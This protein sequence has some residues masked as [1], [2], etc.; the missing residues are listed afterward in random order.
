M[1]N[2]MISKQLD[3][4]LVPVDPQKVE[5]IKNSTFVGEFCLRDKYGNWV[6]SPAQIYWQEKPPVEGYSNYF[7]LFVRDGD[8]LI[9]SGQSAVDEEISAIGYGDEIIFSRYRH[10]YRSSADGAVAIDGGRDY[11]KIVGTPDE[12]LT[13]KIEGPHL[14]IKQRMP[15]SAV[16]RSL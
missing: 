2:V 16:Q 13:L 8:V 4:L 5:K 12:F 7:A 9:T 11:T 10:D 3:Q 14:V 15:Y 6:N 1:T